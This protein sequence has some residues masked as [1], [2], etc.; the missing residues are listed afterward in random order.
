[1]SKDHVQSTSS[2]NENG[3]E[4]GAESAAAAAS[5]Q[6]NY[7]Q[8]Q[9]ENLYDEYRRRLELIKNIKKVK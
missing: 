9:S 6:P 5:Q 2:T 3:G 8:M 1:M 4:T 7:A